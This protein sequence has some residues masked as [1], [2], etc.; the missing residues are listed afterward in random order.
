MSQLTPSQIDEI[1]K[2]HNRWLS[3]RAIAETKWHWRKTV[4][5]YIEDYHDKQII[6]MIEDFNENKPT[7]ISINIFLAWLFLITVIGLALFGV[8]TLINF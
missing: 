8:Y 5:K 7:I 3:Q 1:I 6:K 2:L 4:K